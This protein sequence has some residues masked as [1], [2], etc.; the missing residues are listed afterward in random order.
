[1]TPPMGDRELLAQKI[2]IKFDDLPTSYAE[3]LADV[4]LADRRAVNAH[5]P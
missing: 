1:M 3:W 2:I 5:L 4:I